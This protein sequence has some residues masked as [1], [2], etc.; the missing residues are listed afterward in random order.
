MSITKVGSVITYTPINNKDEFSATGTVQ[1]D[2]FAICDNRDK[3]KQIQF[4]PSALPTNT[5]VTIAAG[6][7]SSGTFTLPAGAGGSLS[8][9]QATTQTSAP[10]EA[11]TVTFLAATTVYIGTP[12]GTLTTLNVVFPSAPANGS[13]LAYTFDHNVTNLN[14]SSAGAD[15][16]VAAPV[17][18]TA[19]VPVAF[20]YLASATKWYLTT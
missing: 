7:T 15:T 20:V 1:Q 9:P 10:A 16:F 13:S 17:A 4:D 19:N 3:L 2:S 18:A 5:T 8:T 6:A 14:I 11:G 12:A